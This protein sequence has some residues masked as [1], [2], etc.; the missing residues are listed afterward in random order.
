MP[1]VAVNGIALHYHDDGPREGSPVIFIHAFPL[2][3]AM[4]DGLIGVLVEAGYRVI[5]PDLRGVGGSEVPPGPYPMSLLAADVL[6]LADELGLDRF[7]LG[8]LSMGGYVS[9][10]LLRQA[11][12]RVRAVILADTRAGADSDEGKANRETTAQKA[13][14]EGS[15]AIADSMLPRL[16]A[17]ATINHK[18]DVVAEVRAMIESNSPMGIAATA[19]GMALRA[20]STDLLPE[21]DIPTLIIV[22][23]LDAITPP[24]ESRFMQGRIPDATLTIIRDAGHLSNIDQP[25]EF[26]I[27]L[28]HFL[29]AHPS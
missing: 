11:P 24:D 14:R 19:R 7:V 1:S 17:P 28:I 4:C 16:L 21:I 10:A 23:E 9:L 6:G 29:L 22:G 15:S 27:K 8:G 20:D 5:T 2:H 3:R 26:N 13:E 18:A 25:E 12:E